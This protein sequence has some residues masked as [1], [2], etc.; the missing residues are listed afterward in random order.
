MSPILAVVVLLFAIAYGAVA[1][2]ALRH[3]L[4]GRLAYREAIRRRGQALLVV[5]G[6]M[7]GTATITAAL[8]SADSVGDS[9]VDAFAYRNWGYVDLT[10]GSPNRFFSPDV[11]AHI[12]SN[13]DVRRVTDG[14]AAGIEAY[15]STSDLTTRQGTSGVTLAGF[16]PAAQRPF[17]AY[18]LLSGRRT[19]GT[20]LLPGQVLLSRVLADK[21]NAK[22]GDRLAFG[23]E[24]PNTFG[25]RSAPIPLDLRV[26]GIAKLEGPG[27][28][29]LSSVVFAPLGTAQRILD[30]DQINVVRIS[31]PGGIR[32]SG[33]AAKAAAP[34]IRRVVKSLNASVPLSVTEAKAREAEAATTNT[35]FIRALLIGMSALVV[36]AGAA[37]V[38]NLIGMLAEER[39]SRMGV[40]RA[41]GLKRRSLVWLSVIEGAWYSL[42]AGVVG[43]VVGVGAGRFIAARFGRAFAEFAGEDFDF[44][45]HYS[46]KAPTI[47]A[48]FA[49]GTFL[50]L[51]VVYFAARRTSR[52]TITAAIRNLPEPPAEKSRRPW[53]RRIRLAL[54]GLAGALGVLI[55]SP[56]TKLVGGI[57]LILVVAAVVKP[58]MSPRT[59]S[60]LLGLALAGLS[61][62]MVAGQDPNTDAQLFFLVFVIAMLTA[63]F[64]LTILASANLHVAET[65]VGLLGKAF[66]GLRATLRPPL[67]YLA[68]RPTRTG[69]TTGVFAV[70][71]GML[72]LFA[73]FFVIF[74]PSYERFGNGYDVRVLSTGSASIELP[75][76]VRP[77][78][79]RS[80][81]L[82]TLGYVGPTD[83][84]DAFSDSERAFVPLFIVNADVASDPPVRLDQ[85]DDKYGSDQEVWAA[86]AR[87]PRLAVTNFGTPGQKFILRGPN[88]PVRYRIVGSQSF[89]LMDGMFGTDRTF[90]QFKGAPLGLSMLIDVKDGVDASAMARKIESGL[91]G[92]GV[93]ADSV[94]KL[95]D[96]ADRAN[97]AF[98]S[99]ID[100]L[101]RM[102]LVVG[103]LSLGIVALRIVV[104]RRHVIGVLRALGYKKLHVLMGLMAE[105]TVTATIGAVVGLAVGVIMGYVFYR[106]QDSQP[107]FGIDFA[108]IGGVLGLIYVAVLLVTLG[109]AWRASRLP[110]A[111]AVRYTE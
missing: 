5:A 67:A 38:V 83:G 57:A 27:G 17:G 12:A 19:Y 104:E 72:S 3:R 62:G 80:V 102:G 2:F 91:F 29:T 14:V 74:R 1:V 13:P 71:V 63:V 97:R 77:Q 43:V 101:M 37:L 42:A 48:G 20:D 78:I 55:P 8:V 98:F 82:P 46:L 26:A 11:A 51:L 90:A 24:G 58:R 21:L 61:F 16:D 93:D 79:A 52:M 28:Y 108:S 100:V 31:A 84:D 56:F 10:V 60:T 4:L 18:T 64:G 36:A 69:L 23:G 25:P 15:G 85:R 73:V 39:R 9:S 22:V 87:D 44:E 66:S 65:I 41:L 92:Q 59:H 35:V 76:A 49:V 96:K 103:I 89:G 40:L 75:Q 109:P 30:T 7:V 86:I 54:F 50:T 34:V 88:G 68:R 105:A 33:P 99:T 53:I 6:L 111:E 106:Q 70:I 107:G 110:P 45:F 47:V 81:S 94:Q 95:L 32:D